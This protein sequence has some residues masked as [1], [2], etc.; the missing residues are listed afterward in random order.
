MRFPIQTCPVVLIL[1]V[2]TVNLVKHV[3]A[4]SVVSENLYCESQFCD[5]IN[6]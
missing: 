4:D 3:P 5:Q 6:N 1:I 2:L